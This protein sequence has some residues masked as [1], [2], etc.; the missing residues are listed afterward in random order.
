MLRGF[1]H[2]VHLQGMR[3]GKKQEGKMSPI[4]TKREVLNSLTFGSTVAEEEEDTL[5]S[6]FVETN[7]WRKV[8]AGEVDIVQGA[9]GSGKSAIY[10]LLQSKRCVDALFDRR[11]IVVT[12]ENPRGAVAFRE[13]VKNQPEDDEFRELW[14]LYF[15][16]LISRALREFDNT[17]ASARTVI[18]SMEAA[19]LLPRES[20]LGGY[21]FSA[22]DYVR[23]WISSRSIEPRVS[24]DQSGTVSFGP[25]IMFREPTGN[26]LR[27]GIRSV[28]GL[29]KL[30]NEAFEHT[31]YTLWLLL[32]RLDVA[33]AE[34]PKLERRALR[35]LFMVYRDL[36]AFRNIRLKIFLRSDIWSDIT[37]NGFREASHINDLKLT[38]D[39]TSLL[40]LIVRRALSND[41]LRNLYGVDPEA[42]LG[43]IKLQAT[44]L[45]KILPTKV[46]DPPERG[47]KKWKTFDWVLNRTCDG[48][49]YN[50]PRELIC[51]MSEARDRQI[52]R[53]EK[54][55]PEPAGTSLFDP[56]ALK[57]ALSRVSEIRYDRTLCAEYPALRYF[58]QKLEGTKPG[59]D[60]ETLS[61]LWGGSKKQALGRANQL[62]DVG[63]FERKG[64]TET[65]WFRVPHLYRP[66]LKICDE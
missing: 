7:E 4:S 20:S 9:K 54:G 3:V 55:Y 22:F 66:A 49:G 6:Y 15:L 51:L 62:A 57:D 46:P 19:G 41:S 53:I 24:V 64:S 13:L 31:G 37:K 28:D 10:S 61:K 50:A 1:W 14:K 8:F 36:A 23:R 11:I 32:D 21:L 26:E 16:A 47:V 2:V 38:W 17:Q 42:V 63:F 58:V 35:S 60:T 44:L 18:S 34:S 5:Q 65:P 30:A 43:D 39:P 56:E 27:S 48:A 12:A 52:N 25:A 40:N 29:M 59:H 45:D 33:F